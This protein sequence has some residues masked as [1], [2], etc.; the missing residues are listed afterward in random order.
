M[1]GR[2]NVRSDTEVLISER[3]GMGSELGSASLLR[4]G[5]F[6]SWTASFTHS[7]WPL[8]FWQLGWGNREETK[9]ETRSLLSFC[10]LDLL[11]R[12]VTLLKATGRES[13]TLTL[14]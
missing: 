4:G 7:P 13:H 5:Q 12:L 6:S 1:A 9:T 10:L 11:P 3:V 14:V 8:S 2:V